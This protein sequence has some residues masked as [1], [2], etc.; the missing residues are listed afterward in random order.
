MPVS[1]D[2][3]IARFELATRRLA[4]VV[5]AQTIEA[6]SALLTLRKE[7]TEATEMLY[8][9]AVETL[10]R[11]PAVVRYEMEQEFEERF[12]AMRR[13][14]ARHQG[15]WPAVLIAGDPEGFRAS[16]RNARQAKADLMGWIRR[17]LLTKV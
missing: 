4:E 14:V 6:R 16:A 15:K 2:E 5:E 17:E 1:I 8:N 11:F 10:T 12:Q 9:A 13:A 7:N 3:A